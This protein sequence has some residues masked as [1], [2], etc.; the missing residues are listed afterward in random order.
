MHNHFKTPHP[1]N[2]LNND[3]GEDCFGDKGNDDDGDGGD[4]D[5][6]ELEGAR[7]DG[8]DDQMIILHQ[9]IMVVDLGKES[10][11]VRYRSIWDFM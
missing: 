6:R 2:R 5:D 7:P 8:D 4:D 9:E 10:R 11:C 3:E 1:L